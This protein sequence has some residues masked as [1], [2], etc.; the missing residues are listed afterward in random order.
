MIG[1]IVRFKARDVWKHEVRDFWTWLENNVDVL[2]DA[3]G[4]RLSNV[5][6]EKNAGDFSV[7]L[8]AEDAS[9]SSIVDREIVD[10]MIRFEKTL[11]PFI[12]QL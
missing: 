4:L 5:E 8:V 2:N 9:D 11:R 3:L 6:R 10:A 12:D 1:R 7:D